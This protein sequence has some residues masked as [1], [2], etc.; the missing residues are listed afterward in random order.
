[1]GKRKNISRTIRR[2]KSKKHKTLSKIAKT[3]IARKLNH[4]EKRRG[5]AQEKRMYDIR[6]KAKQM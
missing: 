5:K 4:D 6:M 1:M 3:V 2:D